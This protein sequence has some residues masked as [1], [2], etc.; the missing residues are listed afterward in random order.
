LFAQGFLLHLLPAL[1]CHSVSP[2]SG[3]CRVV[4]VADDSHI[5][6]A[7]IVTRMNF[8]Y[9]HVLTPR[10]I[11]CCYYIVSIDCY[12]PPCLCLQLQHSLSQDLQLKAEPGHRIYISS[13]HTI[14][15]R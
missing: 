11:Y 6:C 4:W 2:D 8:L 10:P 14:Y 5:F 3:T 13:M 9:L 1:P 7:S 12:S 15:R